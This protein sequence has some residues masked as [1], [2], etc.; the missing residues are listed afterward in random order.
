MTYAETK[1]RFTRLD[2]TNSVTEAPVLVTAVAVV[3]VTAAAVVDPPDVVDVTT[4]VPSEEHAAAATPK[5]ATP[6]APV[7]AARR[8][9]LRET[10]LVG[11]DS[12]GLTLA[13]RTE[14]G[15]GMSRHRGT[16]EYHENPA[17]RCSHAR[18]FVIVRPPQTT[19]SDHG[20][21]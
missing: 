4:D 19:G 21:A 2:E 5:I 12:I 15:D 13:H 6:M 3:V 20:E 9:C 10:S 14:T 18:V 7:P 11:L 16:W 1:S 17:V 8:K